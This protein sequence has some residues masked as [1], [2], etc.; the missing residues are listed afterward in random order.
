MFGYVK[1]KIANFKHNFVFVYQ[2]L[3]NKH[4]KFGLVIKAVD[5]LTDTKESYH[6]PY[7]IKSYTFRDKICRR[8]TFQIV[9]LRSL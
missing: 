4:P 9:A 2:I 8:I 6:L 3:Q 1:L 5:L 7:K